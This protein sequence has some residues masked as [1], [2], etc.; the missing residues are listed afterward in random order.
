MDHQ[1]GSHPITSLISTA[2]HSFLCK[3][4]SLSLSLI[5]SRDYSS[6]DIQPNMVEKR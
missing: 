5:R 4:L 1:P 6:D 2:A 3:H